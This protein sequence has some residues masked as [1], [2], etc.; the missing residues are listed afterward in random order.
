MKS[1]SDDIPNVST[2]EIK[3]SAIV[4]DESNQMLKG[5]AERIS[6]QD[7]YMQE[8]FKNTNDNFKA[9]R[10]QLYVIGAV[11]FA[12]LILLAG[13]AITVYELIPKG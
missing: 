2:E 3:R 12:N 8:Q 6:V 1:Y 9:I 7:E 11:V 5:L 13:T 10:T 4:A